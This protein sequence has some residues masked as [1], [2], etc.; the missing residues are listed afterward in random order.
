MAPSQKKQRAK[1][2][3]P[4]QTST[5]KP[6][7]SPK[8]PARGRP[9]RS[10][11]PQKT[12]AAQKQN[13][14]KRVSRPTSA[15]E[16][17]RL[18]PP[19]GFHPVEH[20]DDDNNRSSLGLAMAE[21]SIIGELLGMRDYLLHSNDRS[22]DPELFNAHYEDAKAFIA[23]LAGAPEVVDLRPYE[24]VKALLQ[25][26]A[27]RLRKEEKEREL[28]VM[29]DANTASTESSGSAA[30]V[31]SPDL[32]YAGAVG[33][34]SPPT[35]TTVSSHHSGRMK[36]TIGPFERNPLYD[37]DDGDVLVFIP[38]R[39]NGLQA[40]K[41]TKHGKRAL[42]QDLDS[43]VANKRT[44][45][46]NGKT[47]AKAITEAGKKRGSPRAKDKID[48]SY[49]PKPGE[50]D[51]EE[52]G[53]ELRFQA[54]GNMTSA[55]LAKPGSGSLIPPEIID[56]DAADEQELLDFTDDGEEYDLNPDE[57]FWPGDAV[58]MFGETKYLEAL[59][60]RQID[61]DLAA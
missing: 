57:Q 44:K 40:S 50:S 54:K 41:T 53:D 11:S 16:S 39:P 20:G 15:L 55:H 43:D 42:A 31:F 35:M 7:P 6:P 8:P 4:S 36:R 13:L 56:F 58:F 48:R 5:R 10:A 9:R 24:E 27:E 1:I 52:D 59:K 23:D 29:R 25:Y 22:T 51:E 37:S 26:H 2:A 46:G 21:A 60:S 38:P 12:S 3:T 18:K 19:R 28:A 34:G 14:Q 17:Q 47:V 32:A 30:G 33:E 45:G 49:K 61:L